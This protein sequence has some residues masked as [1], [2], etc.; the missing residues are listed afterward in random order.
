GWGNS[1]TTVMR[2]EV[3]GVSAEAS[4]LQGFA[5]EVFGLDKMHRL[6]RGTKSRTF[7]NQTD[8]DV[9]RKIAQEAGLQANIDATSTSHAL[10]FQVNETDH[11][12]LR[13][14]ARRIGFDF[15][16]SDGK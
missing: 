7:Q 13:K 1:K 3:T 12:F 5:V 8:A 2:G 9:A 10:L 11:Q 6:M 4:Q 14:R 15:W 16:V